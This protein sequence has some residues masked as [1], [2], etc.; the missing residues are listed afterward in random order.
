MTDTVPVVDVVLSWTRKRPG[1]TAV[2]KS[3]G[4]GFT[5]IGR[6][7]AT[8]FTVK[9]LNPERSYVF[10][11]AGVLPNG[12]VTPES[13]W[14]IVRVAPSA[15][16]STPALPATPSGFA[17]AQDGANV[18]FRW[19]AA[20][21]G[22][23]TSFEIRVG[24]SWEDGTLVASG[25]A[26]SPYAWAWWG[27]GAVTFW[28]KAIDKLGRACL[29]GASATVE[30]ASLQDHVT[31]GASDEGGGGWSGQKSNLEI[32][33]SG[34][35]RLAQIPPHFGAATSPPFGAWPAPCMA[36]YQPTGTY[37]TPDIDAGALEKTRLEVDLSGAAQPIDAAI[38]FGACLHPA[39]GAKTLPDGTPAPHGLRGFASR[40]S[41]RATPL[42]PVDAKTEIDTC[43]TTGGPWDG[44]RP[45]TPGVH[46]FWHARLRVTVTGD[47]TRF[48]QIPRLVV[49]RQKFNKKQEGHVVVNCS[50]VDI[51]FPT[52][53][54]N[55]P[56]VTAAILGYAGNPTITNVTATGFT[57]A[58]GAA[59]FPGD[60]ATFAPT[61]HWQA[62]GT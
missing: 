22:V 37:T 3:D 4:Q 36:R 50:P 58:G 23:T 10:A 35:L 45:F 6:T 14:E 18:N 62:L 9:A 38:P 52:P 54:Q 49:T 44:W 5:E 42:V 43:P 59:V 46:A 19:D 31:A 15:H 55:S 39:L 27:S 11:A 61:V 60:P 57:I 20:S 30:I 40:H 21:D 7:D 56:K 48:V 25:L 29:V 33:G 13:D 2:F 47:G 34:N 53:F 32:D 41:W 26:A 16:A 51:V 24:A 17:A 1:T 28:L 8:T 12:T